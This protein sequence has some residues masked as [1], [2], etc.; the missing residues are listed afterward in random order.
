MKI[1]LIAMALGAVGIH[2]G[3]VCDG[4]PGTSVDVYS[5]VTLTSSTVLAL[6]SAD[7]CTVGNYTFSN[8]QVAS[9]AGVNFIAP[10][11]GFSLTVVV[12]GALDSNEAEFEFSNLGA[13][14]IQLYYTITGG[15]PDMTLGSGTTNSVSEVICSIAFAVP[16]STCGGS[17]LG[18]VSPLDTNG[19]TYASTLVN[20]ANEDFI[21]NNIFGGSEIFESIA[22][23]PMTLTLMGV[24]L[25]GIGLLGHRRRT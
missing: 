20:P 17:T 24:G 19:S 3:N 18:A 7:S 13:G 23:E 22:P 15:V 2:A 12:G 21:V 10:N 8:F 14:D 6:D 5:D 25:A 9:G 4:G 1:I 11:T 16:N